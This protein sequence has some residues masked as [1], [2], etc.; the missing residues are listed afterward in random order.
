MIR[1]FS[2]DQ[3]MNIQPN[4]SNY[5]K[6]FDT[7]LYSPKVDTEIRRELLGI[8]RE[9]FSTIT[10]PL[11]SSLTSKYARESIIY[12]DGSRIDGKTGSSRTK[13]NSQPFSML[14]NIRTTRNHSLGRYL[15]LMDS[16]SS[17]QVLQT[18]AIS[19]KVHPLINDCKEAFWRLSRESYDISIGWVPSH[20]EVGGNEKAVLL[21]KS[22]VCSDGN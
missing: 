18:R 2:I 20:V 22:A 8:R 15:I 19:P 14:C 1:E 16:L 5:N 21:A 12:T 13:Q 7:L 6:S 3:D 17:V 4:M 10:P 9:S 11:V